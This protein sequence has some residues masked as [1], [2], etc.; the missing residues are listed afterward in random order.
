MIKF[1]IVVPVYNAEKY[2]K[3]CLDSILHQTYKYYE[4]IMVVDGCMDCSEDICKVYADGDSRFHL[5]RKEN[6]TYYL[7]PFLICPFIKSLA[8]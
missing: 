6:G 8:N 3:N 7:E 2:L 5:Y 4:V 1:S